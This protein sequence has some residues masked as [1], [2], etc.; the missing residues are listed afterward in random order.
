VGPSFGTGPRSGVVD[1]RRRSIT[2]EGTPMPDHPTHPDIAIVNGQFYA[3]NPAPLYAWMRANAPVYWDESAGVW[4]IASYALVKE[5]SKDSATFSNAGGIRPTYGP[6]PM[7]I[8]MD[9][10]EHWNRRK[11]VNRGFTPKRIRDTSDRVYEVCDQIIDLVCERGECDLVND[12]AALLPMIMIGDMLG[13]DHADH[14]KLLRWSDD[15]LKSLSDT[16]SEELVMNAATAF[17]EYLEYAGNVIEKRRAEPTD[18]LIS[19]LVHADVDGDRLTPEDI[20]Q[21]SL[22]I[23]IGGD[24][25]TRHVISEGMYQLLQHPDQR[26][27][28]VDDPEVYGTAVEEM[29]RWVS[30]IKNMA[31]QLTKDTE[32]HGQQLHEGEKVLLLYASANRDEAVFANPETFDITRTPNDHVA[33]GFGAHF[34]LGNSLA[35]LEIRTMVERLIN[36]LPDLELVSTDIEFRAANFVSGPESIPVRFTPTAKVGA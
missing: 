32:F 5:A 29:L 1:H 34:C 4:G 21:E 14:R 23:L 12:V 6:L 24:E 17:G 33:F 19:V 25:T 16:A 9:D 7:M 18:D 8:D 35:R 2:H 28:L 26:Q 3:N 15:M 20:V 31:R 36:R 13:V 11:L 10:P 27:L 30:P 22:L